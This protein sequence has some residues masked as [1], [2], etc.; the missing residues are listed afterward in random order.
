MIDFANIKHTTAGLECHYLG[1]RK[2]G[3]QTLHR[4]AVINAVSEVICYYDDAGRR[5][6]F[7]GASG[8]VKVVDG[9]Q[10]VKPPRKIEVTRWLCFKYVLACVEEPVAVHLWD[11]E[12]TSVQ[13]EKG[14]YFKVEKITRTIEVPE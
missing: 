14:K 5:V 10:I 8:W 11:V 6:E 12:P 2:S 3:D 9:H 1:Q 13:I 7:S 4:F